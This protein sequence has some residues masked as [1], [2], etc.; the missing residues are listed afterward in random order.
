MQ[1]ASA[2]FAFGGLWL[3]LA[4]SLAMGA[5]AEV[6]GEGLLSSEDMVVMDRKMHEIDRRRGCLQGDDTFF[7]YF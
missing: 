4:H 6:L 5:A 7:T 2:A 1:L 3:S